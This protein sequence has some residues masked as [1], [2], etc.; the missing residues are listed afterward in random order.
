MSLI[1]KQVPAGAWVGWLIVL[2]TRVTARISKQV[3]FTGITANSTVAVIESVNA[4]GRDGAGYGSSCGGRRWSAGFAASVQLVGA[5]LTRH[6]G[7]AFIRKTTVT[8]STF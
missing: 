4:A 6:N 8:E 3:A 5:A 2:V 1:F 7:S